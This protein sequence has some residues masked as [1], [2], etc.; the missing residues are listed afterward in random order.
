[1]VG[2]GIIICVSSNKY[3]MGHM[4]CVCVCVCRVN[5]SD[6]EMTLVICSHSVEQYLLK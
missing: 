4:V 2:D 1:M 5:P 6:L 3:G